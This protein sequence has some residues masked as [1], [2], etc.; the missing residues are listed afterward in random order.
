MSI[1]S[2][3]LDKRYVL[4]AGGLL[5]LAT[6]HLVDANAVWAVIFGAAC[7]V[8]LWLAVHEGR[9][10]S[11]SHAD[12]PLPDREKLNSAWQAQLASS[13]RWRILAV[14]ATVAA[15]AL[16]PIV[17]PAAALA[18]IVALF[19]LFRTVRARRDAVALRGFAEPARRD[20]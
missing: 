5:L 20:G 8:N 17:A 15:A 2:V 10:R 7:A 12:A 14:V 16:L 18:A 11:A 6:I 1:P 19:C 13:V 3:P 4:L 9:R